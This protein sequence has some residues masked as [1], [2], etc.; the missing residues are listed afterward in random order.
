MYIIILD[1]I[2]DAVEI[3]IICPQLN[4]NEIQIPHNKHHKVSYVRYKLWVQSCNEL[5]AVSFTHLRVSKQGIL[6]SSIIK[7]QFIFRIPRPAWN[8]IHY[9]FMVFQ[10]SL[11]RAIMSHNYY[12][13]NRL[14]TCY[15]FFC[16]NFCQWVQNETSMSGDLWTLIT[17]F[18]CFVSFPDNYS[19]TQWIINWA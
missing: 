13:N 5:Q 6:F 2:W 1:G 7:D 3:E 17:Q 16:N 11:W 10:K 12:L 8:N 4:T 9:W 19:K 15:T 14:S 18:V